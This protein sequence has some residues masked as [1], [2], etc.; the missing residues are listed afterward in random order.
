MTTEPCL[1]IF[2][3]GDCIVLLR[4]NHT[5]SSCVRCIR[6]G[7]YATYGMEESEVDNPGK[8]IP[9][10]LLKSEATPLNQTQKR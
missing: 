9:K 5:D 7:S 10:S 6:A 4:G 8:V 3:D 1:L 2:T